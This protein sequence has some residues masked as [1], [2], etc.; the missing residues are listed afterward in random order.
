MEFKEYLRKAAGQLEGEV[1][2]ILEGELKEAEKIDK[3]L[4]PL[5]KAFIKSCHG[6]KRIR[7]VLIKLGY[8]IVRGKLN[9]KELL[10]VGA[11][12]EIVHAA[13]LAHDDII[14]QSLKRR[15]K[16][17]LYQALGGNHY[18]ISQAISLAD[19]GF[20]LSFKIILKSNFPEKAKIKVLKVFSQVMMNTTWGELLDLEDSAPD[21]V[22]R[23]KTACYTIA[24]PIQIGAIL[25]GA[26]EKL[27]GRLGRFGENLGIAFQIR[28]DILDA[29]TP[30]PGEIARSREKA[31]KL[32]EQALKMLP[33]ITADSKMSKILEQLGEYLVQRTK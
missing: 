13:I 11:S 28:D 20:F 18:G 24:G 7:G 32:K 17:S 10:K 6:G 5:L 33:Q 8:D 30:S 9:D 29:E 22:M 26:E 31:E 15:G 21:V 4:V 3:K 14:D 1:K 25:A 23:L 2:K 27:L 19:Y 12:Y 16:P